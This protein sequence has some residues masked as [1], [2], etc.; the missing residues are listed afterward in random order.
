MTE[1]KE[2]MN[3]HFLK[4]NPDKTEIIVFLPYKFRNESLINGA[5]LGGDCIRF[6][7]SVK[8]L[9]FNLD[10]FLYMDSHV[11][12]TVSYCYKL[13]SDVARIRYLLSNEDTVSLM[14]AIVSSRLDY[15]NSL[16][17]G[18]NK[19]VIQKFQKVQNAAARLISKRK[20]HESVRDVLIDLHWLPVEQR[21]I[22]KL[23]V[24]T[25]KIIN[26]LAPE[27]LNNLISVR[28]AK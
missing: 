21:I 17:Y 11:D 1:I 10:R 7:Q 25:Y 3:R 6:G 23:L 5:F 15:C 22:F 8:N 9:G 28:S 16:L 4:I 13:I 24:F 2:W 18:V 20:K 19:S 26:N 12:A 14:H 27:C